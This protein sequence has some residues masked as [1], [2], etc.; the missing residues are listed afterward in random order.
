MVYKDPKLALRKAYYS[1]INYSINWEGMPIKPY[2][3]VPEEL[4]IYIKFAGQTNNTL[5]STKTSYLSNSTITLDIVTKFHPSTGS[6]DI[7]DIIANQLFAA[8]LEKG[9]PLT[10]D[11]PFYIITSNLEFDE[12][13]KEEDSDTDIIYRRILR[14]QHL[15]N[16][17]LEESTEYNYLSTPP[18]SIPFVLAS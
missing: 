7:A 14:F 10:M 9:K 4:D 12:T 18:M 17:T 1:A 5:S 16:Q 3:K 8:V 13:L 15:I 11:D 6:F 2:S